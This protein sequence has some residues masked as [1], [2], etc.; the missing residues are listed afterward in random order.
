[1]IRLAQLG[2]GR[3]SHSIGRFSFL[4]IPPT[5]VLEVELELVLDL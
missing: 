3:K 5:I 2:N 4:A 1:M